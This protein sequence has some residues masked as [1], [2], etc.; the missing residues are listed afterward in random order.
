MIDEDYWKR[1]YKESWDFESKRIAHII[2]RIGAA[3]G[4][5]VLPVGM[6][7][8]SLAFIAGC[9]SK[10]GHERGEADLWVENTNAYL[11]V[12]G[13][14]V[15][16]VPPEAALWVR[17]DK[18]ENARA[19]FP[20]HDTWLV[21]VLGAHGLIRAIRFDREFFC[22][23]DRKEFRL[24]TPKPHGVV[25]TYFEIPASSSAVRTFDVLLIHLKS[26]FTPRPTS[27]NDS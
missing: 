25:E 22:R 3:T 8:G 16:H 17:P 19:H 26:Q 6:G 18:V 15:E 5:R 10:H 27:L 9:A 23:I 24:I 13:P 14:Q 4:L 2:E 12:T 21:H 20:E 1:V 11:E 7:T